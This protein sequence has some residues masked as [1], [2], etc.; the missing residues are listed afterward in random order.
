MLR[1]TCAVVAEWF[2][3]I[4]RRFRSDVV[5]AVR[6]GERLHEIKERTVAEAQTLGETITLYTGQYCPYCRTVKKELV[7]LGLDYQT[8][9]ADE[10]GR[11][12]VMRLSGQRAIPILTIDD[13]VLVDS[14]NII[15]QLRARYA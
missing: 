12:E 8:V 15:R 2:G 9:Q 1:S 5:V 6:V 11:Q 13:E 7:R 10:D 3:G 4:I 14:S